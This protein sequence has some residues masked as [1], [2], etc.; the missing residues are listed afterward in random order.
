LDLGDLNSK[1][2]ATKKY[3]E[4]IVNISKVLV[5]KQ[6]QVEKTIEKQL[7]V[8]ENSKESI[9][10]VIKEKKDVLIKEATKITNITC[11]KCSERH[12][13][14][15]KALC[16][17]DCS[18]PKFKV[19]TSADC[20]SAGCSSSCV[21]SNMTCDA[22]GKTVGSCMFPFTYLGVKHKEC[23]NFSPFGLT[24]RPWCYLDTATNRDEKAAPS[25][26]GYCDCTS[27]KCL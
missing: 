26:W 16:C 6:T 24:R 5:T 21:F 18:K 25:E 27:I 8:I 19:P 23:V 7:T 22:T 1:I 12:K 9:I 15:D 10:E 20:K 17:D 13:P 4:K 3:I 11:V 14:K 2:N